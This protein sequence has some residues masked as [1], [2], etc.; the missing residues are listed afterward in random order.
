MSTRR[1]MSPVSRDEFVVEA[2]EIAAVRAEQ[3][4]VPF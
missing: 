3:E 1:P 2:I 4:V